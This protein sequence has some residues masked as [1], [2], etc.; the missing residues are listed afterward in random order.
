M[1][2]VFAVIRNHDKKLGARAM[3][4]HDH[5]PSISPD[6]E[7][8]EDDDLAGALSGLSQLSTGALTLVD[9]LTAVAEF[10]VKAIPG[11]DGAGVTLLQNNEPDTV[12]ASADFVRDIDDIQYSLGQG[13]CI[14][15]AATAATV[16][17]GSLGQDAQWPVFGP[18]AQHLGVHSVLSLPLLA[19]DETIGAMN[20][21]AYAADAFT[22]R[23]AEL[24]ELFAVP[25]AVSVA[26]AR[27]LAAATLL[28]QRLEN[29]LTN[30]AMID[31]AIGILISRSGYTPA[32]A[33]SALR[34]I[35]QREN[36]KLNVVAQSLVDDA[37]RRAR[38]RHTTD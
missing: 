25:A 24:G 14:T 9:A 1:Q 29:A 7:Q 8:I 35:S 23:A 13:P 26:N 16:R 28:A 21:Y 36:R 19:G 34:A 3:D 11:A 38:A 27:A 17:S 37:G 10:G 20:V 2:W 6:A 15:A 33:F 32:E 4:D 5:E 12:V 31:H 18:R 22:E 30:R